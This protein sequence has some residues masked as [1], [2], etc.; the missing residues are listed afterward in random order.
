[1]TRSRTSKA[2]GLVLIVCATFLTACS[3]TGQRLGNMWLIHNTATS[4]VI[5][6]GSGP[7]PVLSLDDL[8]EFDSYQTP[9]FEGLTLATDDYIA[10]DEVGAERVLEYID[11]MLMRMLELVGE[12]D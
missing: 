6:L 12:E 8:R 2:L 5:T 4:S 9:V 3:S 11:P 7:N 1:M 10:G